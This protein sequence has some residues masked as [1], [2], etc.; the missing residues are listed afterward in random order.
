[1]N[2]LK[3]VIV[4]YQSTEATKHL[5]GAEKVFDLTE[6]QQKN[7]RDDLNNVSVRNGKIFWTILVA[8]LAVFILSIVFVAFNQ[9]KPDTIKT[10]FSITGVSIMGLIYYMVRIWKEK[11]YIDLTLTLVR[12]LDKEMVNSI[13]LALLNK[14]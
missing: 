8:I 5:G 7:L 11:N 2:S 12:T 10:I 6:T 1:M 3:N 4:K 14:L 13:L 9:D